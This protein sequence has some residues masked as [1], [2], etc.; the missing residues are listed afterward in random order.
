MWLVSN[1]KSAL[2]TRGYCPAEPTLASEDIHL[3]I[4]VAPQTHQTLVRTTGNCKALGPWERQGGVE[5]GRQA[6]NHNFCRGFEE[7][8]VAFWDKKVST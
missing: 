1:D 6:R 7:A 2:S 3:R 5:A 4:P 8:A